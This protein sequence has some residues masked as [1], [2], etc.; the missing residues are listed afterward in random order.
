VLAEVTCANEANLANNSGV[1]PLG[2]TMEYDLA[3]S[4]DGSDTVEPRGGM[5]LT[6]TTLS[7]DEPTVLPTRR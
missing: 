4:D 7:D 6:T 1:A 5:V 2:F 3:G